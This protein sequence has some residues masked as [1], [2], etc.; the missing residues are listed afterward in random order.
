MMRWIFIFAVAH[1]A[2]VAIVYGD[3]PAPFEPSEVQ[4]H[5][6]SLNDTYRVSRG[7]WPHKLDAE[8]CGLSQRWAEHMAA[9]GWMGHGGGENI[10]AYGTASVPA[11]MAMW[12]ASGGHNAHLLSGTTRAGWGHAVSANGTHYW[13]GAFRG[14][15]TTTTTTTS[16]G[17]GRPWLGGWLFGRRR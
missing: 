15:A 16:H 12:R 17:N 14:E 6:A 4:S 11:T 13:A 5:M 9:R 3:E 2:A 10:V 7:L 1:L 8:L